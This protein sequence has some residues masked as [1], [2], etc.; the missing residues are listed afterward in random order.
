MCPA[1]WSWLCE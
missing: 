1:S